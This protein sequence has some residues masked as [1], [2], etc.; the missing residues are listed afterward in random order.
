MFKKLKGYDFTLMITPILLTAFGIV[1]IYSASM[2]LAVVE[3]QESTYYL[4]RQIQWFCLAMM[5]FIMTSIFPYKYYQK[6][7][8][9]IVLGIVAL[10]A[11]V[12]IF[13]TTVN[14]ARSWFDFGPISLQQAEFANLGIIISLV[15]KITLLISR[16]VYILY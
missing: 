4:V 13:G 14:N 6:L 12:L 9:V 5:G 10:L 11:G 1:M 2:V 16:L 8:K 15:Q 7:I 3:G